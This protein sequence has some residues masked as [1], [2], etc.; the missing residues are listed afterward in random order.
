MLR[1]ASLASLLSL[2]TVLAIRTVSMHAGASPHW[3][4]LWA[5][6]GGLPKGTR[7]D[8]AG[9]SLTL[10]AELRRRPPIE[11]TDRLTALVPGCGRAYDAL[12]LAEHGYASV[13]A[14]DLSP[15]ACEAAREELKA[16]GSAAASRVE[17]RCGDFF[18][19]EGVF[20]KGE[21]FDMIWD[22]TFLC[23]LDPSVR[24]RWAA[25]M[26]SLL[27]PQGELLTCVFPIGDRE[28]GPPYAMSVPL[29]RSLLEPCG[30][31]AAAVRDDLPL[32]EQHR[33]PGDELGSVLK[34][35]TAL[36]IW[37]QP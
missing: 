5:Q 10:S 24:E 37:Q 11:A 3:E 13:V 6:D 32:E 1:C 23:A 26:R 33:R 9:P 17:V 16:S 19:S 20:D 25:Q 36:I 2:R 29:V 12:A 4:A 28:G 15:A 14:L 31:K 7:F 27:A 34:R 35:G 8:V 21:T 22:C 30:L 18:A